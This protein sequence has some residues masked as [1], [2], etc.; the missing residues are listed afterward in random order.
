MRILD[1]DQFDP[2]CYFYLA[3][4]ISLLSVLPQNF[5]MNYY[6]EKGADPKK[7]VMGM[8]CYGQSFGLNDASKHGLNAKSYGKGRAGKYT[9]AAGFL[10]FYEV[11]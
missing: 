5:T 9:R 3:V 11:S 8:P 10:A 4:V 7:M 6:I 1:H 2:A